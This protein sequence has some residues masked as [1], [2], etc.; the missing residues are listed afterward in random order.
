[1]EIAS[2]RSEMA[3][4]KIRLPACTCNNAPH[5]RKTASG[6]H[7]Q[8]SRQTP[9]SSYSWDIAPGKCTIASRRCTIISSYFPNAFGH[10]NR[11]SRNRA[12]DSSQDL[13]AS[14]H[15]AHTSMHFDCI[16]DY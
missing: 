16:P 14:L 5:N 12:K 1:M 13:Q 2:L 3:S 10:F 7:E 8:A 6:C 11:A 15:C 9:L 4:R